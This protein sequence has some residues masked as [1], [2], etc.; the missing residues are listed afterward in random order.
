MNIE[1]SFLN[2]TLW[3]MDNKNENRFLLFE[4]KMNIEFSFLNKHFA[5]HEQ[6]LNID[7]FFEQKMNIEFYFLNKKWT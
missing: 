7:F 1:F 3:L 2:N 5:V 4:Q 6:T